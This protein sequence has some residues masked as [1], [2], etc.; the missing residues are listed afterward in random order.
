MCD[1]QPDQSQTK[2]SSATNLD[3]DIDLSTAFYDVM[4]GQDDTEDEE[5][6]EI[7]KMVSGKLSGLITSGDSI[8]TLVPP[9]PQHLMDLSE[10]LRD[11]NCDFEQID[12]VLAKDITLS[13]DVVKLANSPV[14]R[15]S[16]DPVTSTEAA[17]RTIG[18]RELEDLV[19]RLLMKTAMEVN[20]IYFRMFGKQIWEHSLETAT[21]CRSLCGRQDRGDCYFLGL[22][23]DIGKV[24]VFKFLVEAFSVANPDS[25]PGSKVFRRMMTTYS[26]RLSEQAAREWELPEQ[27]IDALEKQK[28]EPTE[29]IAGILHT[30]NQWSEIHMLV[31]RGFVP[32]ETGEALIREL[33]IPDEVRE[34]VQRVL[35]EQ[36]GSD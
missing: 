5:L 27:I 7:E 21:I 15:Q 16:V 35:D 24:I 18:L 22:M 1:H 2:E 25:Q 6:N 19:S 10:L 29:E 33:G 32:A 34:S 4:F 31:E 13:I 30:G 36:T 26:M 12:Q 14:F 9:L 3:T 20:P 8:T 28:F 17:I 11:G 23:H